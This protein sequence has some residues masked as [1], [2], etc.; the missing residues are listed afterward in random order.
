MGG[1]VLGT[2]VPG[3]ASGPVSGQTL[4]MIEYLRG[5]IRSP[6]HEGR[7]IV[8]PH[9]VN[10]ANRMGAG[11][12][13]ALSRKWPSVK[14][15]YHDWAG[16]AL[17]GVPFALGAVQSV[18]VVADPQPWWVINMVAQ[19]APRALSGPGSKAPPPIRY[20]AL[21]TCLTKVAAFSLARG[22]SVH[23][24]QIGSKRA[25]GDWDG[26]IVPLI[27]ETLVARCVPVVVYLWEG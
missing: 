9:I 12:A 27:E 25:G 4:F 2:E 7:P 19:T 21:R 24:P 3:L 26:A 5:D 20:D 18:K 10:D 11:V 17:A 1:D 14:S 8:I 13:L 23:M 22:A 6:R 15:R 16:G